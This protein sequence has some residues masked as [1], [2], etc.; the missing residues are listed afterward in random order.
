MSRL[1]L[2]LLLILSSNWSRADSRAGS[3][4]ARPF[5]ACMW[6]VWGELRARRRCC[7]HG[8]CPSCLHGDGPLA[9]SMQVTWRVDSQGKVTLRAAPAAGRNVDI[10]MQTHLCRSCVDACD[11]A[12][13]SGSLAGGGACLVLRGV[14]G[15]IRCASTTTHQQDVAGR[16]SSSVQG[17]PTGLQKPTAGR[18]SVSIQVIYNN[19]NPPLCSSRAASS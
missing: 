19:F 6:H 5:W 14:S 2:P 7:K 18:F 1:A 4:L 16:S 10:I 13:G 11:L 3:K 9:P 12:R 17:V 8:P 15:W